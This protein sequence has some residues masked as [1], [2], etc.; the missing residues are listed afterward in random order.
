MKI[1]TQTLANRRILFQEIK[2]VMR[3]RAISV[4][5]IPEV[6]DEVYNRWFMNC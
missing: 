1:I 2:R 6:E 3:Q 4:D 5:L